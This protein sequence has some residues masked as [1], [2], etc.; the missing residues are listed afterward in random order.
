M[1]GPKTNIILNGE[2]LD[3]FS[4]KIRN[5]TKMSAPTTSVQHYAEISSQGNLVRKRNKNHPNWKREL[6][7][8]SVHK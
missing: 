6:K 7:T 8:I 2:R 4:L 5:E 3:N 1:K